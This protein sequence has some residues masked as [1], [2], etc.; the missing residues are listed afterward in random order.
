MKFKN[1]KLTHNTHHNLLLRIWSL[2]ALLL[3]ENLGIRMHW[4]AISSTLQQRT[5]LL[6]AAANAVC[7]SWPNRGILI[8]NEFVWI[9]VW[10]V[11]PGESSWPTRLSWSDVASS[12]WTRSNVLRLL[13]CES[14]FMHI[15]LRNAKNI[16]IFLSLNQRGAGSMGLLPLFPHSAC[17][18][19]RESSAGRVP[20][21]HSESSWKFS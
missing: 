16:D 2:G 6:S 8:I 20:Q 17:V 19:I 7:D 10:Y 3:E 9:S 21:C 5:A 14:L 4:L 11:R 12:I 18:G 15:S 1:Y 13:T